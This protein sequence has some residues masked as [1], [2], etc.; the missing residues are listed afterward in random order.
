MK[1]NFFL[2]GFVL[3]IFLISLGS[4]STEGESCEVAGFVNY[5]SQEYCDLDGLMKVQLDLGDSCINDYECK[6][7]SCVEGICKSKYSDLSERRSLFETLFGWLDD[8]E[9][10]PLNQSIDCS[11]NPPVK[12]VAGEWVDQD[13][14]VCENPI[15]ECTEDLDCLDSYPLRSRLVCEGSDELVF[16][17]TSVPVCSSSGVC[18]YNEEG[19][20]RVVD[21]CDEDEVC[22][23]EGN[24]A[25]CKQ[26]SVAV[27]GDGK[28]FNG[29]EDCEGNDNL[30]GKS[31]S[32]FTSYSRG[33]LACYPVDSEKECQFDFSGCELD[34][35][36]GGG[37]STNIDLNVISP[38]DILYGKK[39]ISLEAY[40]EEGNAEYWKYSLNSGS[41][42]LVESNVEDGIKTFVV[43]KT[44]KNVLELWASEYSSFSNSEKI[45]I[46][47]EVKNE[48]S[49]T[50]G[51]GVCGVGEDCNNCQKDCGSCRI[52]NLNCDKDGKCERNEDSS[53]CP[54]DCSGSLSWGAIIFLILLILLG[55]GIIVFVIISSKKRKDSQ[56]ESSVS[57]SEN[58]PG[59]GPGSFP[60]NSPVNSSSGR[61]MI[62]G[63]PL[64]RRQPGL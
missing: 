39:V 41:S 30:N 55:I 14:S 59:N 50:C 20:S 22:V 58:F 60:R 4:I 35:N 11:V 12:C 32:S 44:G 8:K 31:C 40:D 17:V 57:G 38:K 64:L 56:V 13:A 9:C 21:T 51:N 5:S 27:C 33:T 43:A 3:G 15:V 24:T 48:D 29:V 54:E 34:S 23:E 61:M 16:N 36:N 28:I 1:K 45:L 52:I 53:T 18:G 7:D 46:N 26:E 63:R 10:D 19:S 25:E 62:T 37:R 2:V 42:V 49:S 47:F 6:G